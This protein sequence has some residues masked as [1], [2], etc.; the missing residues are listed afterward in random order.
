MMVELHSLPPGDYD[1]TAMLLGVD[2]HRRA[3]AHA[4]VNMVE[5]GVA[6]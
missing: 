3:I 1:V 6:R 2:G 5:S 4:Q